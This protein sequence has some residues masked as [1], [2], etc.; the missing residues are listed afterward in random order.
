MKKGRDRGAKKEVKGFW[1]DVLNPPFYSHGI[2]HSLFRTSK[3]KQEEK[4]E[5]EDKSESLL[6]IVSRGTGVEQHR[7]HTVELAVFNMLGM[8]VAM[9]RGEVYQMRREH[10]IFSGISSILFFWM[11]H[12]R[13]Q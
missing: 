5:E 7:H 8:V 10:E 11:I 4:E 9:E 12:S 13:F 6:Q 3:S 1:G 2:V